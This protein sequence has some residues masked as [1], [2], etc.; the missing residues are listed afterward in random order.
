[1]LPAPIWGGDGR[2]SAENRGPGTTQLVPVHRQ[3]R[4]ARG[5]MTRNPIR[6]PRRLSDRPAL[7]NNA[8][9]TDEGNTPQ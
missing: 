2:P 7:D 1:M 6:Q 4:D 8:R 3:R 9:I 5:P